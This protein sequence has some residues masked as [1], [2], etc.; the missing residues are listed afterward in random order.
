MVPG[1]ATQ[2]WLQ[3][4]GSRL[5]LLGA[6]CLAAAAAAATLLDAACMQ[7]LGTTL[8]CLEI[9]LVVSFISAVQTQ[10]CDA[11]RICFRRACA[12]CICCLQADRCL[13]CRWTC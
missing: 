5:R 3:Q 11:A 7:L 4:Q 13:L 9:L 6:A 10:V 2:E 8:G 12:C 1:Q